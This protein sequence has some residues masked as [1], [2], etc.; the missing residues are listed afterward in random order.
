LEFIGIPEYMDFGEGAGHLIS[1]GKFSVIN[2]SHTAFSPFS[3][4]LLNFI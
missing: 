2:S 4:F 1:F 3:L